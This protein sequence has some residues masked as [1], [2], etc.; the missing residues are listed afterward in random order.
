MGTMRPVRGGRMPRFRLSKLLLVSLIAVS[1]IALAGAPKK[2][3][4]AKTKA[5]P[6]G[7]AKA[8]P[9]KAVA[10]PTPEHKKKLAELL[11]GY[12]FG[13]TKDEVVADFAK[14]LDETYADKL[15]GT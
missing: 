4:P 5:P 10:P 1:P 8:P 9:K 11:G 6:K 7:P 15:K 2:A 13:M 14:K 3:P 12:K